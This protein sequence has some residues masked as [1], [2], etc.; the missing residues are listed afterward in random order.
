MTLPEQERMEDKMANTITTP[1][2]TVALPEGVTADDLY[3]TAAT[4]EFGWGMPDMDIQPYAEKLRAA[5]WTMYRRKFP[6][7]AQMLR[8]PMTAMTVT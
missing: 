5:G 3:Y 6:P 1:T 7:Y 8:P 4:D 2:Y